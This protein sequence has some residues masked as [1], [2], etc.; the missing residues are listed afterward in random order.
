MKRIPM[1]QFLVYLDSKLISKHIATFLTQVIL[2]LSFDI[3]MKLL[4]Y[5]PVKWCPFYPVFDDW[6][7]SFKPLLA[8][9]HEE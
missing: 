6:I 8:S 1:A 4:V 9:C 2:C 5:N 7:S 3:V